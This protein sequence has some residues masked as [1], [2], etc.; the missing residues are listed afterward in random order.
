MTF[1]PNYQYDKLYRKVIHDLKQERP[2]VLPAGV[3][4]EITSWRKK[5]KLYEEF[6]CD[7]LFRSDPVPNEEWPSIIMKK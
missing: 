7:N 6:P 3:F 2:P 4:F 5:K 1:D